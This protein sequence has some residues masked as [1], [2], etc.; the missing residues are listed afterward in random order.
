MKKLLS[1]ILVLVTVLPL[2]VACGKAPTGNEITD[3]VTTEPATD[4]IADTE[5]IEVEKM[6]I[7]KISELN[8]EAVRDSHAKEYATAGLESNFREYISLDKSLLKTSLAFYPR[9]KQMSN[10][11]FILFYQNGNHGPDIYYCLSDDGFEYGDPQ[12]L[13]KGTADKLYSTCDA[14]V[15]KN[16]DVLAIASYRLATNYLRYPM[17]SGIVIKRSTDN[18]ATWSNEQVI[19]RG[20]NWEP[21]LLQLESGEIH[22]YWT[23]TT[24]LSTGEGTF[25]STGTAIVRSNDNGYTWTGNI[26]KAMS[27][28]IVSQ[29]KTEVI[30]GVQMFSD[31]M[32]VA[33]ELHNGRIALAL[34]TRL[35][36]VGS[37]RISIAHSDDNWATALEPFKDVGPSTKLA[38]YCVGAGP[39]IGQFESGETLISYNRKNNLT[40]RIGDDNSEK[41]GLEFS[42]F[43]GVSTNYWGCFDIIGTHSIVTANEYRTKQGS[44]EINYIVSGR[45]YLNH[46]VD[47][48]A[49][50][51]TVDGNSKEWENNTDALF[52]GSVSQAQCSTRFAKDGDKLAILCE[53]LDYSRDPEGDTVTVMIASKLS[54]KFHY[55]ITFGEGGV[56]E[57]I[58]SEKGE[59]TV[60]DA[61]Q[62]SFAAKV[63]EAG[64]EKD[65]QAGYVAEMTVPLSLLES[66]EGEFVCNIVLDNT[67]NGKKSGSDVLSASD[68]SRYNTWCKVRLAK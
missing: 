16:G 15:L 22:A 34:E 37:F 13:F 19:F 18:G 6:Y 36:R 20:C 23:N 53:R 14:L 64:S 5:P 10:G 2:A 21:S 38:K 46:L 66:V 9:V 47:A 25:T 8:T 11:K 33:V 43:A 30:K 1:L 24:G 51:I 62:I 7:H 44:T 3:P 27:G 35:D 54:S 28:Q 56:V 55:E 4:D 60:L 31:Q 59:A 40:F 61:S 29:Q 67:D 41:F 12:L 50:A 17:Q 45:L 26:N 57:F 58:K 68:I 63:N 49:H 39:Y 65:D 48:K 52:V 32:P 42:P